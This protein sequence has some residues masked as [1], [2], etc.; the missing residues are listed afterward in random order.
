MARPYMLKPR[1]RTPRQ[2][3]LPLSRESA[4]PIETYHFPMRQKTFRNR[5]LRPSKPMFY[6]GDDPA[7]ESREYY[8]DAQPAFHFPE[9]SRHRP[10]YSLTDEYSNYKAESKPSPTLHFKDQ[11]LKVDDPLYIVKEK[12]LQKQQANYRNRPI[13]QLPLQKKPKYPIRPVRDNPAIEEYWNS[14]QKQH[15][16]APS[17]RKKKHNLPE[18]EHVEYVYNAEED[19]ANLPQKIDN[20]DEKKYSRLVQRETEREISK[21]PVKKRKHPGI[22]P[23]SELLNY[24]DT[25]DSYGA[26]DDY[27]QY[28]PYLHVSP[29]VHTPVYRPRPFPEYA[30]EDIVKDLTFPEYSSE[31]VAPK[32]ILRK[33]PINIDYETPEKYDN[34]E[35]R[36]AYHGHS[37]GHLDENGI[38][39]SIIDHVVFFDCLQ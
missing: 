12:Q 6:F 33:K 7:K 8:R 37:D 14:P 17:L 36:A 16:P 13:V 29:K 35:K 20:E 18:R 15:L 4:I 22:P 5:E 27:E 11:A 31:E 32:R 10:V 21:T 24:S 19:Y 3:Y 34:K 39:V 30:E 28:E 9:T 2:E 26:S 25:R 1:S 23:K 38:N